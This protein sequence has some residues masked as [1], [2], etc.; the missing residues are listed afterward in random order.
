MN[1]DTSN[2]DSRRIVRKRSRKTRRSV[3]FADRIAGL[4]IK[5]GGIG[6][7]LAVSL[8]FVF[9]L[10]VVFP[11]FL[12]T[13]TESQPGFP[14]E[15]ASQDGSVIHMGV[16]EYLH[17][18]WTVDRDGRLSWYRSETGEQIG[19][20]EL[21]PDQQLV[22]WSFALRDGHVAFAFEDATVQIG[23]IEFQTSFVPAADLPDGVQDL[24]IGT[25][26]PHEGGILERTPEDQFRLQTL[27][28]ELED[29]IAVEVDSRIALIDLSVSSKGTMFA[30]LTESGELRLARVTQRKNL[31]TGKITTKLREGK[32]QVDL[33][34]DETPTQILLAGLGDSVIVTG[35]SG[36]ALRFDCRNASQPTLVE[37][38]DLVEDPTAE[39]TAAEFLIGKTSL[40]AG[41][42]QGNVDVWFRTKPE[43]ATTTDGA[44]LVRAHRLPAA[45]SAV[46]SLASSP[47]SRMIAAGFA[48]RTVRL[49]HVTSNQQLAEVQLDGGELPASQ[50]AIAPK[51]DAIVS[52]NDQQLQIWQVDASHPEITWSSIFSAVWYEGYE[53]PE[54]SWQSSSGT[55]EFEEKYGMIPLV[56]GTLKSTFYS[57]LFAVPLALLA[58]IY[59][60]EFLH[61]KTKARVKPTI[62]IMASLP[63]VVLG[64]LAALFFAPL[65]EDIVP[66]VL[67]A[68][69]AIPFAFL[70]GAYLWQLLPAAVEVR[71]RQIRIFGISLALP[72]GLV[73][74]FLLGDTVESWLFAGDIKAWLDGQIGTGAGAWMFILLPLSAASVIWC[75]N[76]YVTP[77]IRRAGRAWQRSHFALVDFGKF[78]L[79]CLATL[80][81]AYLA[82][83]LLNGMGWDPRGSYVGTYVQRN[84]LIVGAIMGF[85]VIPII[86]TIADDAL[87]AVPESIRA[88][89]LGAG[90]TPWQTAIRVVVPTAMSG[91]FSAIMVG[92]GRAVGETMI[93]LMAAG[94][95]ALMDLNLFNGFRTL[96]ANIAVELPEAVINSSHYRMLFLAALLLFLITFVVNTV[97]EVIRLRFRKRAFQL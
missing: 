79:A 70:L 67:T 38:L 32:A 48:D 74:A 15:L 80:A 57:M 29:P 93:V 23:K 28:A 22:A 10:W 87:S 16:N 14:K 77:R 83:T 8:V 12:P 56:F 55:D 54:H 46:I 11:L 97:A 58:A 3:L 17:I 89:S 21:F 36:S 6:T 30:L 88:A 34:E 72:I 69:V 37:S 50:L 44:T 41:D 59:T 18:M 25:G 92:L 9:L 47:R 64:F 75:V 78:L 66:E 91:L 20:R 95:T 73:A 33:P 82:S 53:H 13:S 94:N 60:S 81:I 26:V 40:V 96:S 86:Y 42:S 61:P 19:S 35:K 7:I 5:L 2:A 62:E 49:Y 24:P 39:L 85:A 1:S 31:L 90:A 43:N 63:S 51:D 45:D 4:S 84:S 68:V 65:V 27:V 76:S 52:M 71:A